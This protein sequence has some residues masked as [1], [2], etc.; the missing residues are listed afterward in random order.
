M[1]TGA[2]KGQALGG[3]PS[4]DFSPATR[5]C[6]S[7]HVSSF[8]QSDA[9]FCRRVER[10]RPQNQDDQEKCSRPKLQMGFHRGATMSARALPIKPLE[11]R[12][13][14]PVSTSHPIELNKV[15]R[16]GIR[17]ACEQQDHHIAR[18]FAREDEQQEGD[19]RSP[20]RTCRQRQRIADH[21]QPAE[22]QAPDAPAIEPT[23]G[24][25][26]FSFVQ[27]YRAGPPGRGIAADAPV[28][29]APSVFPAVATASNSQNSLAPATARAPSTTSEDIGRIVEAANAL[30]NRKARSILALEEPGFY[31]EIGRMAFQLRLNHPHAT[32]FDIRASGLLRQRPAR[33]PVPTT[34]AAGR[35]TAPASAFPR[36]PQLAQQTELDRCCSGGEPEDHLE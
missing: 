17:S 28:T 33:C 34:K 27:R 18:C 10:G 35:I 26:K 30:T 36:R 25:L 2:A 6:S 1:A 3:V 31:I 5:F 16:R 13:G 23:A 9:G 32:L 20:Q 15:L 11:A 22:Q 7:H 8:L 4:R 12:P 21:R 14:R 29:T 19:E 24:S